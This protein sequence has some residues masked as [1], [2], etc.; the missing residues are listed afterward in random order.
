MP[1]LNLSFIILIVQMVICVLPGVLGIFLIVSSEDT[2]RSMR[3]TVCN[4]LFGV[5]NAIECPKFQRFLIIVGVLGILFS[6]PA[7]WF[8]L[9]SK[10]F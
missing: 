5:S 10:F 1:L 8:V 9:L 2:K 4:Q 7:T 3:N 6:I